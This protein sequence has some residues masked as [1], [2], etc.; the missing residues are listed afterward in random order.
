MSQRLIVAENESGLAHILNDI[1]H[2][3]GLTRTSYTQQ[4]LCRHP[5]LHPLGQLLNRLRL[6]TCRLKLRY[7]LKIHLSFILNCKI[8]IYIRKYSLNQP[9]FSKEK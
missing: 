5:I 7:Q 4:H 9:L 8:T 3:E 1:C 2:R 6:V